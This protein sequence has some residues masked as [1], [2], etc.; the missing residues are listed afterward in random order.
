MRLINKKMTRKSFNQFDKNVDDLIEESLKETEQYRI[1]IPK[2]FNK[3]LLKR[4]SSQLNEI[5]NENLIQFPLKPKIPNEFIL[6]KNSKTLNDFLIDSK[7]IKSSNFEINTLIGQ[8]QTTNIMN[9]IRTISYF[10]EQINEILPNQ[11]FQFNEKYLNYLKL[12]LNIYFNQNNLYQSFQS[13]I[14]LLSLTE[15]IKDFFKKLYQRYKIIVQIIL[16]QN[17]DQS[18]IIASRSLWNIHLDHFLEQKF[19]Q[20][21]LFI[22]ILVF[23]ISKE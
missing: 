17:L 19:D 18:I 21:N 10:N 20:K 11:F 2:R 8:Y 23:F 4:N 1:K 7:L 9:P 14:N 6:N 5:K 3:N 12:L 22:L 13:K 16:Q 15:Q